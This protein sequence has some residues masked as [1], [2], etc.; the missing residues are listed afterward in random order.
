MINKNKIVWRYKTKF[1]HDGCKNGWQSCECHTC[2]LA[3]TNPISHDQ[4]TLRGQYEYSLATLNSAKRCESQRTYYYKKLG[5][6]F[7]IRIV[8]VGHLI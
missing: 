8:R 6:D 7:K 1:Q 4:S 2:K 3:N 5:M